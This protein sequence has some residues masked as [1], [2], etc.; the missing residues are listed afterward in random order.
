M[1]ILGDIADEFKDFANEDFM[2]MAKDFR[3]ILSA[4]WLAG[5]G[6]DAGMLM[7]AEKDRQR[8]I[9]LMTGIELGF[10]EIKV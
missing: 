3:A 2:W 6:A 10:F 4:N 1:G 7:M 9:K 8:L 5:D